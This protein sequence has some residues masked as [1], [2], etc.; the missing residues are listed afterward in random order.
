MG[1][2]GI[3]KKRRRKKTGKKPFPATPINRQAASML[4]KS[5]PD[6]YAAA[7]RF[8]PQYESPSRFKAPSKSLR[9]TRKRK[10]KFLNNFTFMTCPHCKVWG[11]KE[12]I[13]NHIKDMH[14][15]IP[16]S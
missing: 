9:N 14:C 3:L 1:S 11:P 10:V 15:I 12:R 7:C 6:D 5:D 2:T 4:R 16:R 8:Q 13:K